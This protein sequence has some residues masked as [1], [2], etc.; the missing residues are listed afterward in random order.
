LCYLRSTFNVC[1]EIKQ[2]ELNFFRFLK[3]SFLT[4]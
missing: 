4:L 3:E 2:F 1:R